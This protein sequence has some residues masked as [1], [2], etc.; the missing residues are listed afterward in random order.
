MVAMSVA[1]PSTRCPTVTRPTRMCA[2]VGNDDGRSMAWSCSTERE[3]LDERDELVH[4]HAA[5][6]GDA[7]DSRR[8]Q[9]PDQRPH[10]VRLRHRHVV[11]DDFVGHQ[12]DDDRRLE[13]CR[14][15]SAVASDSRLRAM[16][17]WP[18]E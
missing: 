8:L 17:G 18:L 3:G 6:D 16:I 13:L 2:I 12:A 7:L 11:D 10:G 9:P 15:C 1:L 5:I 14:S 4:R